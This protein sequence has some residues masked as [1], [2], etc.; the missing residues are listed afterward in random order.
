MINKEPPSPNLPKEIINKTYIRYKE[1]LETL[2][3]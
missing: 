1:A 2:T 3:N